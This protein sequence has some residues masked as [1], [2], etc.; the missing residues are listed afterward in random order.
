MKWV[1][2]NDI[3]PLVQN[4]GCGAGLCSTHESWVKFDSTLTQM[5][6][7]RTWISRAT[8]FS[9]PWNSR[10]W[11]ES[12]TNQADCN[13]SQSWVNWILL[14]SKLSHWFFGRENVKILQL[15]VALWGKNQPT[16]AFD[17]TPPP[18]LSTTFGPIRQNVMSRE[19]VLTHDSWLK[20][21]ESE[22]SQA[23]KFEDWG[24]SE[25]SP[26]RQIKC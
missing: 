18:P 8:E 16:A 13:L 6:R 15:S 5:S 22:L 26:S 9:S 12:E 11:V 17:S 1:Y 4:Q 21:V 7:R 24:K 10:I 23:S 25:L 2:R 3:E 20:W 19:P 14:E